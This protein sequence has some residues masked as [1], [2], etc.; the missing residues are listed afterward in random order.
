MDAM[1]LLF[2][3]IIDSMSNVRKIH[4]MEV[5]WDCILPVKSGTNCYILKDGEYYIKYDKGCTI[6]HGL[7]ENKSTDTGL[8]K[9][10]AAI[11]QIDFELIE[12]WMNS[13]NLPF[14]IDIKIKCLFYLILKMN[15]LVDEL[16]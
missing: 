1:W 14:V 10:W 9:Y 6:L 4:E 2:P 13:S 7:W 3:P 16:V 12:V 11:S 5:Q 8:Y 15:D